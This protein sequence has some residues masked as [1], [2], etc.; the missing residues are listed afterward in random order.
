MKIL[1]HLA[2]CGIVL[3]AASGFGLSACTDGGSVTG[4]SSV[5]APAGP[6][7]NTATDT[8]VTPTPK[9]GS[10]GESTTTCSPCYV[11]GVY[12]GSGGGVCC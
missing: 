12:V 7:R 1:R 8:T 5:A 9:P 2:A 11:G 3:A 6:S 10:G 4:P